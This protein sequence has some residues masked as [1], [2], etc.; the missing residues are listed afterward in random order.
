MRGQKLYLKSL[1]FEFFP[2]F[3]SFENSTIAGRQ[4]VKIEGRQGVKKLV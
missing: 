4:G 1:D 3:F 2:D